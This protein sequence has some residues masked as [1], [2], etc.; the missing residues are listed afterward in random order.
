[1]GCLIIFFNQINQNKK[2]NTWK[3]S[4]Y[5]R[6]I[7]KAKK[8]KK[9][10]ITGQ[11]KNASTFCNGEKKIFFLVFFFVMLSLNHAYISEEVKLSSF[12]V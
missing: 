12:R 11:I 1:M 7:Y 5:I 9:K 3:P 2:K 10:Q 8:R 6:Y 4:T